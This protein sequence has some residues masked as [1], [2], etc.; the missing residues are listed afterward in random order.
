[1]AKV[2]LGDADTKQ[3]PALRSKL[4]YAHKLI[5]E[6][7]G[8]MQSLLVES[9]VAILLKIFGKSTYESIIILLFA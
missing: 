3:K 6:L 4:I 5:F 1:M 8:L 2:D 9:F 7:L